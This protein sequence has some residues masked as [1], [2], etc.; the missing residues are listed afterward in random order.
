MYSM[1]KSLTNQQTTT[2]IFSL[3]SLSLLTYESPDI[4]QMSVDVCCGLLYFPKFAIFISF[5]SCTWSFS[6]FFYIL[7][8][9]GWVRPVS[10]LG[11][12]NAWDQTWWPEK[13][14]TS[15]SVLWLRPLTETENTDLYR[16]QDRR[17][18][19]KRLI[20]IG[21]KTEDRDRKYRYF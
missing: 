11:Y 15:I 1:A 14:R 12:A 3:Y 8:L 16:S 20:F 17:P 5:I 6:R 9:A 10:I 2:L 13:S 18:R 19:P 4:Q 21:H 7:R